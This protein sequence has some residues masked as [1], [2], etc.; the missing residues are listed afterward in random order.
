MSEHTTH[1]SET[2]R[3]ER[4]RSD[5]KVAGVAGGLGRYFEI[6]PAFFRVGFVVLT[7]L[8]GAGI[9][10][11]AAAALVI[12]DEGKED[13]IA[14][15]TLRQRR[16]RPWPLIGLGLL[17]VG[18][19]VVLADASLW[20]QGDA[21]LLLAIAGAAI[22]WVTRHTTP[23]RK[24]TD[25]GE[26]SAAEVTALAA[27]DSRR[28]RRIVRGVVIAFMSFVAL[29]VVA[30][31]AFAAFFHVH[32]GRGVGERTYAPTTIEELRSRYEL[33]VGDLHLDLTKIRFPVGETMLE[34]RVDVGEIDVT[35]PADVAVQAHGRAKAG[36]VEL[37]GAVADGYKADYETHETGDRVLVLDASTGAG[38]VRVERV[39]R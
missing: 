11:Y 3:L 22:L 13:S 4:S 39:V 36:R 19:A 23:E 37:L 21:W 7:L 38:S 15:R 29:C 5:R 20:P 33:G 2:T 18:G 9:L 1:I 6:H 24:E 31:A 14:T 30:V 34:A 12:P 25:S 10:I 17:A 28:M 32:V 16:D 8:G 35:V 27:Q 26:A